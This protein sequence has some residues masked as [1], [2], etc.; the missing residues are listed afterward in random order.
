MGAIQNKKQLKPS[1]FKSYLQTNLST[2]PLNSYLTIAQAMDRAQTLSALVIGDGI[3]DEYAYVKTLGKASKE[4]I[5]AARLT[6]TEVFAGG[7]YAAVGHV[8]QF[9]GSVDTFTGSGFTVKR[10][11]V[12]AERTRK[13]FEV[14][15]DRP[16]NVQL[17]EPDYAAYDLVIVTDFGHGTVTQAMIEHLGAAR[18]LAINCQTNSSNYGFNLI[19]KY[20]HADYVVLDELEARLA[21]HDRDGPIEGVIERLGFPLMAVTLGPAGSIG[22]DGRFHRAPGVADRVVDTM[23]AGDAFF[24]C[25]APLAAV[26]LSMPDLLRVGNAAGAIKC[27][28]VGQKA[29]TRAGIERVLT[30]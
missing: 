21:A 13:L 22:Y 25:T 10:R 19:T 30:S 3:V 16:G 14:H 7:V 17:I 28:A 8:E 11:F 18:F 15:D 20:P 29:I 26:G 27:S 5:I 6:H 4:P 12:E 9:C 1:A 23:G 2:P 24:C